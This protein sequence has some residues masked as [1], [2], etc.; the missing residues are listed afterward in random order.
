[1]RASELK[2]VAERPFAMRVFVL[3]LSLLVSGLALADS[4]R[5]GRVNPNDVS[6]VASDESDDKLDDSAANTRATDYNSSRSNKADSVAAP[7]DHSDGDSGDDAP[8][9]K[10]TDY[11]SS[12]SN[13]ADSSKEKK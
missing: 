3:G 11:N 8:D 4:D 9:S 6:A 10:A 5:D 7:D 1:M 2:L 13:K 12:R